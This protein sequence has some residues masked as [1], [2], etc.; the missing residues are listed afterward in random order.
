MSL[1]TALATGAL[2]SAAV[3]AKGLA[4]RLASGEDTRAAL[5]ARAFEFAAA[6]AVLGFGLALFFA[7]RGGG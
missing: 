6:L 7:T 4:V 1:G 3:Y 5:A 2:A